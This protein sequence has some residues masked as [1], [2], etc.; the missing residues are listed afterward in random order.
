MGREDDGEGGGRAP[1]EAAAV[2]KAADAPER[3]AEGNHR[4][5][6]VRERERLLVLRAAPDE[7]GQDGQDQPAVEDEPTFPDA[8]NR[9]GTRGENR[10]PVL[11]DV[12]EA[13]AEDAGEHEEEKKIGKV[14]PAGKLFRDLPAE[15]EA[16]RHAEAVGLEVEEAEVD[17][18]GVHNVKYGMKGG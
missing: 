10:P 8:E 5:E 2:E 13:A 18:I 12:G 11:Y 7:E 14:L 3:V 1:P 16:E 9:P 17:E 15:D 4:G 6:Q